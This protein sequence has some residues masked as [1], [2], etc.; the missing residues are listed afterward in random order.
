MVNK[1]KNIGTKF[2]SQMVN[3]LRANGFEKAKREVLHGSIDEGDVFPCEGLMFECKAGAQAENASDE[4]LRKWC[5]ETETER[6]N[7]RVKVGVLVVKRKAHGVTKMGGSWVVQNDAGM[8][9]RFRLDEY[10]V[11][12]K[13]L[14]YTA[15]GFVGSN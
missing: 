10:L 2:E 14:G 13:R 12:L 15:N 3:F 7:A 4:Q 11:F 1:S 5:L 8:L 9:T 6:I